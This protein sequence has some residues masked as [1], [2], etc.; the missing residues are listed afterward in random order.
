MRTKI[1]FGNTIY[2]CNGKEHDEVC[3]SC[4]LRFLCMT[5]D[6]VKVPRKMLDKLEDIDNIKCIAEFMFGDTSKFKFSQ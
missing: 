4:K 5:S 2:I 6:I 1:C 3:S